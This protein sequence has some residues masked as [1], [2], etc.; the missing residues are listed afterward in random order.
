MIENFE[1]GVYQGENGL[2]L[3]YLDLDNIIEVINQKHEEDIEDYESIIA[4]HEEEIKYLGNLLS[5][6]DNY[7]DY[8]LGEDDE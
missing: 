3:F 6:F 5:K 4:A 1:N 2:S 8:E 7:N